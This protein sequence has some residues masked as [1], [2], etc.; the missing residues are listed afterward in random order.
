MTRKKDHQSNPLQIPA[1][2][3]SPIGSFLRNQLKAL[4]AR[5]ASIEKEDPFVSGRT[6]NFASPDTSAAEQFGHARIEAVR[7]ELDKKIVQMRK[8]LT[9][10]KVGDYGICEECGTMIDTDRLV[11]YPEATLCVKCEAKKEG[12]RSM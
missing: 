6:E 5:R 11:V 7:H 9:R 4:E 2:L 8:A 3:L 10:V 12:R 1:K